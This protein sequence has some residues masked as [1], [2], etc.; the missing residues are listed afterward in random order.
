[1]KANDWH[2]P[3]WVA[4]AHDWIEAHLDARPTGWIEEV[5]VRPWSVTHRVPTESGDRWF[6]ANTP[7]CAYEAPLAEAL[8]HWQPDAV[9][10]PIAVDQRGW[11][12]TADAGQ[13]LREKIGADPGGWPLLPTW[14]RMLQAYASL[15]RATVPHAD[16]MVALGVPDVRPSQLPHHLKSLLDDITLT[17]GQ[18]AAVEAVPFADWC[19]ELA[20][21]GIPATLQHDDLT[22]ANVFPTAGSGFRFF[23]WGDAGVAHPFASLLVALGFAGHVLDLKP[24]APELTRLRD[25]YLEPWTDLAP[26]ATLRRSVTLACRV[27][28][29]ARAL[30]WQRAVRDA[31][32]PVE[33][34]F[35][36][37]ASYWLAEL[38]EPPVI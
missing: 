2:D 5:R 6:K 19:A 16:E 25:A 37:A 9:L 24:G 26:A 35:R 30:A 27:S 7:A 4:T 22:D 11:L 31:S 17:A 18:S 36:T 20:A 10:H 3:N 28:R 1:M 32:L 8:S 12:L 14:S 23:D 29:V 21:D 34:D 38:P 15:Q 33:E 13:T